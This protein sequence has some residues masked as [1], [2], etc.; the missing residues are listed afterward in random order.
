MLMHLS[1]LLRNP[2]HMRAQKEN[3]FVTKKALEVNEMDDHEIHIEEHS[4]FCLS[5]E[6]ENLC[7]KDCG[8]KEKL[9]GHI[10]EHKQFMAAIKESER[11]E[12]R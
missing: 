2:H 5:G 9:I 10:R 8:L 3:A 12:Q 4:R 6:F 7:K 1:H 11:D